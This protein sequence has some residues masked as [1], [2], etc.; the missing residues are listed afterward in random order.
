MEPSF[1]YFL[2]AIILVFNVFRTSIRLPVWQD[3]ESIF[4][5]TLVDSPASPKAKINLGL[6]RY[7]QKRYVESSRLFQAAI[8]EDPTRKFPYPYLINSLIYQ[9]RLEEAELW[10]KKALQIDPS[11]KQ[12]AEA[13]RRIIKVRTDFVLDSGL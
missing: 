13:L 2:L 1:F 3:N 5:S 7:N 4:S 8:I 11:N 10:C 6:H 9:T 12:V